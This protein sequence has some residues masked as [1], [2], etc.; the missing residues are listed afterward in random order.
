MDQ[1]QWLNW[2][3]GGIGSSDA[4]VIVGVSPWRTPYQIWEEKLFGISDQVEN[5]SMTRGK[6]LEEKARRQFEDLMGVSVF[7]SNVVNPN[8]QWLRASLDGICPDEKVLVEI[9]CPNK[10]DHGMAVAKKIPE[11]YWPQC[12][13][14]LAVTGLPG[15]YYYSFDGSRGVV[16]E[17]ARDQSYI[18]QLFQKEQEFWSLVLSRKP[19]ELTDRDKL[20]MEDNHQWMELSEKWKEAVR[21]L[22]DMEA[23][24]KFLKDQL[25]EIA[26]G[27]N[28]VGNGVSLSKSIV[29]GA[30]DCDRIVETYGIDKEQY[31]K[32]PFTKWT[33]RGI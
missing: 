3:R 4:A 20:S 29:K 17:V 18:D 10:D 25:I 7:P 8:T 6:E 14:Q 1:Q 15:M 11:K 13:H 21:N 28:S 27:R 9:K 19:P 22:K 26:N 5:S 32:N 31:R 24:E 30:V 16:V 12:Q 23:A 33:I 2:R